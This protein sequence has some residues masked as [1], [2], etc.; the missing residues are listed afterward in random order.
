[1]VDYFYDYFKNISREILK[2]NSVQRI[3]AKSPEIKSQI[4]I[5]SYQYDMV[6]FYEIYKVLSGDDDM[7][8]AYYIFMTTFE[9]LGKRLLD[10]NR[11]YSFCDEFCINEEFESYAV[12]QIQQ[13][14]LQEFGL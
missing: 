11:L 7:N 13:R 3:L 12:T 10:P 1:L 14:L 9:V 4:E 5:A 8:H 2:C 6:S